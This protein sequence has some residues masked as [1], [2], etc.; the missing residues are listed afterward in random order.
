MGAIEAGGFCQGTSDPNLCADSCRPAPSRA[1]NFELRKDVCGHHPFAGNR[2]NIACPTR[3]L[4]SIFTRRS[5]YDALSISIQ[6][7]L[8]QKIDELVEESMSRGD[9]TDV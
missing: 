3:W 8:E 1:G 4:N 6:E 7:R 2:S 9:A 5:Q